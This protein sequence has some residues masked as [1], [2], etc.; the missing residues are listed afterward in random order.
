MEAANARQIDMI[1]D[2][3]EISNV[4]FGI[5]RG[6][7]VEVDEMSGTKHAHNSD[8]H[9]W[10]AVMETLIKSEWGNNVKFLMED[11]LRNFYSFP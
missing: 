7:S 10:D 9:R 5:E 3:Q 2:K 8:W 6:D 11:W 1:L 4:K